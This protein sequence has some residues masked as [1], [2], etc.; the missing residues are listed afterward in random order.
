VP[1]LKECSFVLLVGL[2][3]HSVHEVVLPAYRRQEHA[4]EAEPATALDLGCTMVFRAATTTTAPPPFIPSQISQPF[5]VQRRAPADAYFAPAGLP[6]ESKLPPLG[7]LQAAHD[8]DAQLIRT[9]EQQRQNGFRAAVGSGA[10]GP[11]YRPEDHVVPRQPVT[12][13]SL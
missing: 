1:S 5:P 10:V 7:W 12:S 9:W 2:G 11:V 4:K 13:G 8:Q 3:I 6:P